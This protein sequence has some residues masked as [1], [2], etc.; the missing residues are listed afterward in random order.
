MVC[1]AN[2]ACQRS[3]FDYTSLKTEADDVYDKMSAITVTSGNYADGVTP[4]QIQVRLM[5]YHGKPITNYEIHLQ[6]SGEQNTLVPCTKTDATGVATCWLYTTKAETKKIVLL[7][8]KTV[9]GE[10]D[11]SPV[12]FNR[13]MTAVVSA[14]AHY[15]NLGSGNKA[16]VAAGELSSSYQLKDSFNKVRAETSILSRMPNK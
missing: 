7:E 13:S 14:G 10:A 8:A 6:I 11:F 16:T 2:M 1:F 12:A 5:N 3:S 4:A 15:P 9:W